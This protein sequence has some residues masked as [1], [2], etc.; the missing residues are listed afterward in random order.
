[1]TSLGT[2]RLVM[3]RSESTIASA[4]PSARPCW[5]PAS[6]A[7]RRSSGSDWIASS[8]LAR[9]SLAVMPASAR[10]A[11]CSAKTC[12]KNA[13]TACPKMIGSDTFIIVALR[14]SEN[15][16]SL[17]LASAIWAVRNSTRAALL[18][19]VASKTSPASERGGRLEDGGGAV[20]RDQLDADVGGLGDGDGPLVRPEVAGAHRGHVGL[21]V[22]RPGAHRVRVLAGVLLH[23]GRGPAVGVALAQ[24]RVHGAALDAVV[25]GQDVALGVRLAGPPG[26]RG[27]RSPWPG[28]PRWPPGAAAATRSRWA[29]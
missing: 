23:R 4:G 28:A 12:G 8:R 20:G 19:T 10:A 17:A 7:V 18:M 16:T 2:C 6:M 24:H 1:M 26:S 3:P 27:G 25:A 9:P 5:M 11:P 13:S 21:G 22:G 14:W 15:S 29:A